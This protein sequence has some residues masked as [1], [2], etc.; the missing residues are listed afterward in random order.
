[1]GSLTVLRAHVDAESNERDGETGVLGELADF[2]RERIIP[3]LAVSSCW[4]WALRRV[5][6]ELDDA[7]ARRLVSEH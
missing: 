7:C 1:M 2:L 5:L 3:R 6:A 4:F